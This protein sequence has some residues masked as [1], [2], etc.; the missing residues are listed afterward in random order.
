[1]ERSIK[2]SGRE[3]RCMVKAILSGQ[4]DVDTRDSTTMEKNKALES[5]C[6]LTEEYIEDSGGT[7]NK[8]GEES[9]LAKMGLKGQAF[10][11]MERRFVGLTD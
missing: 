6:G 5:L 2:D 10:G 4:M 11:V 7:A 9:L 1:M 3:I 8:T